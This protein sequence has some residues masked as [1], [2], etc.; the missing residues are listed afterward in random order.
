[1]KKLLLILL[2]WERMDDK[3]MS[4]IKAEKQGLSIFNYEDWDE[5]IDFLKNTLPKF[6]LTFKKE[7]QEVNRM[8]KN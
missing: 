1:M 3:R 4:R 8:I 2:V 5:M 6:E 7:I